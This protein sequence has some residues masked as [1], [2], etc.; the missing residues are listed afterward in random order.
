VKGRKVHPAVTGVPTYVTGDTIKLNLIGPFNSSANQ[1]AK[2]IRNWDYYRGALLGVAFDR[3]G[4]I[5]VVG[6][7]F[8][9]A[10]GLAISAAHIFEDDFDAIRDGKLHTFAFGILSEISVIWKIESLN[11]SDGNDICLISISPNSEFPG[12]STIWRFGLTTRAPHQGEEV[13]LV[14]FRHGTVE[15]EGEKVF[16]GAKLMASRGVIEAVYPVK[17]DAI[18][19]PYPTLQIAAES[20]GGMSGGIVISSEGLILG[21]IARGFDVED[22]TGPTFASW[23][24]D[25]IARPIIISWPS[26]LYPEQ[27]SLFEMDE[28]LVVIDGKEAISVTSN[29]QIQY[30]IW[31]R[32]PSDP[33]RA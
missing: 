11:I 13:H 8:I 10:P 33:K 15:T 4:E 26:G 32:G 24:I 14:G 6:T 30:R 17:R 29:S 1:S 19:M 25:C 31:F 22:A 7:A 20:I 16:L 12:G 23:I 28:K 2:S 21:V 27:V 18:L 5:G 3:N 9:V